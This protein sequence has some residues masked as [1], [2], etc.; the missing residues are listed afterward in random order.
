MSKG[1]TKR[2]AS[3]GS[4]S[5]RRTSSKRRDSL[6]Q[7][8]A[9]AAG[10]DIGSREHYV[11]VPPDRADEPVRRFECYTPQLHQMGQ[12]L[13]QC[14]VE[15]VAMESTGVYWIPVFEVLETYGLDVKLVD[16]RHV[17]N[18]PGR[19]TDVLDCQWM[20]RLHSHGLLSGAF[21]PESA[22]APLRNFWR[23]RGALVKEGATQIHRMQ[24]ALEQMN[25]QL[26]KVLSDITGLT[27]IKIIRAIDRG[28]HNPQVLARYR[29]RRVKRSEQEIADALS[30]NYRRDH[31]FA[32]GQALELYD[33]YQ[34]KI[35][36]CDQRIEAEMAGFDSKAD[37]DQLAGKTKARRRKNQSWFDLRSELHRVTGVDL[38][39]IEGI[40]AL[41]AQTVV[42][43]GGFDM[44]RFRTEKH[45]TS[46][47]GLCPNNR[48]TGSK[49][50]KSNTRKVK[51]RAATA[52]RVAAQSLH[53]S[54]TALGAYYRRMRARLGPAKAI[55]ATA[56]KLARLIYRMLKY[57][58]D[59][60]AKGQQWYEEQYRERALRNLKTRARALG[61]TII[62]TQTGEV[63]S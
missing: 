41:T 36:D 59:Y 19:K 11:A 7:M 9:N 34:D 45:Y 32:L 50:K 37:P 38:T 29:D 48:I 10:I 6:K 4:S 15:T 30:G 60:I 8:N 25:V 12:W 21:L 13:K 18:V 31:L 51:N 54:Q 28:E 20:Q 17:R 27:G 23:Q 61:Y 57:G 44:S 33:T 42:T 58:E 49:V 55:T 5:S 24:K 47:L 2:G 1:S 3:I 53:K 43:E 16:A 26:H 39:R 63:V 52:L 56:H 22:M 40:D 35:R 46:W 62:E 14:G